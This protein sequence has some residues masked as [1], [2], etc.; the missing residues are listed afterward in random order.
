MRRLRA[1][2]FHST[3]LATDCLDGLDLRGLVN[4]CSPQAM[5]KYSDRWATTC[6]GVL[7]RLPRL[8][9]RFAVVLGLLC[10]RSEVAKRYGLASA[11]QAL[12]CLRPAIQASLELKNYPGSP[13][14]PE[15]AT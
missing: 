6:S 12:W 11:S 7:H 8:R 9:P 15:R 5:D 10:C 14:A 1:E 2:F 4:S 13:I 3:G